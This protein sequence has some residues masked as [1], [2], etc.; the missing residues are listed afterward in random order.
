[1]SD[2]PQVLPFLLR[3]RKED[4]LDDLPP[5]IIQDVSC[6]LSPLQLKLYAAVGGDGTPGAVSLVQLSRVYYQCTIFI[7]NFLIAPLFP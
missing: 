6:D 5:K 3:R 1:M 4:V 2:Y 7:T